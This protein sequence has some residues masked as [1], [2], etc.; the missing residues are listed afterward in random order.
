MLAVW[1]VFVYTQTDSE[2][3]DIIIEMSESNQIKSIKCFFD[4]WLLLVLKKKLTEFFLVAQTHKTT[5]SKKYKREQT[6]TLQSLK[7]EKSKNLKHKIKINWEKRKRRKI[8][9]VRSDPSS[10]GRAHGS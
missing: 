5:F 6:D 4:I 7:K 1:Q 2:W 10:V 3:T 8:E 9:K